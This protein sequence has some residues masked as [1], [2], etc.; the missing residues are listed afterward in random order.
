MAANSPVRIRTAADITIVEFTEASI[1]D[2]LQIEQLGRDL[3][4]LPEKRNVRKLVLD[5]AN[6]KFLSSS[7]LGILLTLRRKCDEFKGK[8]AIC[9]MRAEL[10]K[11]FRVTK[12]DTLFTFFP[13]CDEALRALGGDPKADPSALGTP[14]AVADAPKRG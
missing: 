9:N 8:L 4:E 2:S 3:N 10:I 1:L 13:S 12:L 6:V 7:A 11:V 14:G 5:F